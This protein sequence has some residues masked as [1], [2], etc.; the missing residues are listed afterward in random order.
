MKNFIGLRALPKLV[1]HHPKDVQRLLQLLSEVEGEYKVIAG[2]TDVIPAI[3]R[4]AWEFPNGV[5]FIDIKGVKDLN[6]ITKEGDAVRIGAATKLSEIVRSPVVKRHARILS[7]AVY[8]MASPQVR[9]AATVG[10]NL[11][12]ASPAA[13]SAPPLLVLNAKVKMKSIKN[14]RIVSLTDFFI[15]PGRTVLER[16]EVLSEIQF[17]AV[18]S[19]EK[20]SRVKMG[21]RNAFTL[22]VMSV[23]AWVRLKNGL[24]DCV[25]IALGAVAPTPM[26]TMRAER[27]LNGQK[28]SME[29][30]EKAAKIVSS[31]VKPISDVRA[32]A[33]Y[34]KDMAKVLTKRTLLSC[35][36]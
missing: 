11:C 33:E 22:S 3:R 35:L 16:G 7:E 2:C 31:E 4:G 8:E 17:P 10:G 15:G 19:N 30:I 26:R 32:S 9:N 14:E 21:R 25:R 28:V 29:A 18:Q 36:K 27:Y 6:F 13:D 34:R 5:N 1:F 12:M 20:C 24:F 23:A